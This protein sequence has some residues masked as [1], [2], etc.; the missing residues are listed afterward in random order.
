MSKPKLL[1]FAVSAFLFAQCVPPSEEGFDDV[2]VD[3]TDPGIQQL[4]DLQDRGMSDSLMRYF[5]AKDATYRYLSTLAFASIKDSLALDSLV[6]MLYDPVDV[7]RV[8]AAYSLGQIGMQ[9]AE[10]PLLKAFDRSDTSGVSR[11]FNAA[12]MEAIGKCGNENLV[13]KL[14]TISTYKLADTT[15]MEGQAWGLY[16]Y[17]LRGMTDEKGT[18][19]M[20][21]FATDLR[22]PPSV[23]FIA[24]NYLMRAADINLEGDDGLI[25]L[26]LPRED[27]PRI[28]MALVIALGK[29]KSERAANSLL[30]QYNLERD[31]R[32]KINILRALTNFD[33]Q[34]TKPT[35]IQALND[36]NIS[37]AQTAAEFFIQKGVPEDATVYWEMAKAPGR[38]WQVAM[39]LYGA[40]SKHL[41]KSFE[42]SRRYLNWELRRQYE[43]SPNPYQKAA[44]LKALSN[45]G[46]NYRYIR[47][48]AY[49]SD[50]PVVRTAS[51]EALG[52]IARMPNFRS[53]FGGG[54]RV[55]RELSDCFR[56]AI[57]NGD[58]GM[59]A[60]A[61]GV[62]RDPKLKFE[63]TFDSLVILENALKG[64]RIPQEIETYN[65]VKKTL[66][67]FRGQ[68]PQ[69][70]TRPRFT[71]KIPWKFVTE[72]KD[73]TR[74]VIKTGKGD[75]TLKLMPVAAPGTV[76]NFLEM[77][78]DGYYKG[79]NFHR[80]VP[81]FV[82][83]GGCSRGDGYSSLS[84]A[85]RS[86]L[87][88]LHYDH[89]GYVGM[90]SA[91]NHTESNQFFITH[92]P[93]PH[94]DG[95]YTIFA[96]VESGMDVVQAIQVGDKI[97]EIVLVEQK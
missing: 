4:Y 33:Y 87:P 15:L 3:F 25:S 56:D 13:E 55:K 9:E 91:G 20:L 84:H 31:D 57:E 49:P 14:A 78:N 96:K 35:V 23:R 22:Y 50:L 77:I 36:Q 88:Y 63:E 89:G 17:A 85:I 86:E 79:K 94:L 83:Q 60:V 30:Y 71:H 90:A 34:K 76:A 73:E 11:Y 80:V 40:A 24:A 1:L 93:T 62:L 12:I 39:P 70:I 42:E 72:L 16:R 8:S 26:A 52:N 66:D 74:A 19:K 32:V 38:P 43:N 61:A 41:P 53:F 54:R 27:D 45:Y 92:S 29:T 37:V 51:V 28:R 97:E 75:I 81:N 47:D 65:E 59:M 6:P 69:P 68:T 58:P 82:I 67:Y 64:L 7:V 48:A 5:H 44:A 46:W 21:D 18:D 2:Y 10:A 95:N